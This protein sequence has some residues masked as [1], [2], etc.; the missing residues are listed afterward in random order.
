M[1]TRADSPAS[2]PR[3]D[4]LAVVDHQRVARLQ[5]LRQIAHA[6]IFELGLP[7]GAHNQQPCRIARMDR[8]ERNALWRQFEVEEIRTHHALGVIA[9]GGAQSS[10]P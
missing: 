7:V 1:P 3:R 5:E 4:H 6:P 2:K 8:P 9:R 10:T